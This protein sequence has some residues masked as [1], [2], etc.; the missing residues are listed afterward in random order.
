MARIHMPRQRQSDGRWDYTVSSDEEGWAHASGYCVGWE[1]P[2]VTNAKLKERFGDHY[3]MRPDEIEKKLLFKDK[4]HS[5]GHATAEEAE[6]CHRQYEL[7]FE[8]RVHTSPDTQKKC[9]ICEAWT[10]DQVVVGEFRFFSLCS[11]HQG[12]THLEKLLKK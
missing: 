1:D 12:R 6:E 2:E 10:S 4:F 5:D 3:L 9:A 7:D 11:M 8:V